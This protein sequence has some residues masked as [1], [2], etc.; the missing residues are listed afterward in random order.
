ME[1]KVKKRKPRSM[2]KKRVDR[3]PLVKQMLLD[4]KKAPEIAKVFGVNKWAIYMD[5]NWL[6]EHGLLVRGIEKVCRDVV[7][8]YDTDK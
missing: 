8:F 4:G 3:L 6:V 5:I 1:D 7:V 2:S